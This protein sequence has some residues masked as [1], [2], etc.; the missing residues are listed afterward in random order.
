MTFYRLKSDKSGSSEW[1][2]D[3][4]K[5]SIT[6]GNFD[7]IHRGHQELLKKTRKWADENGG[8]AVVL[9][10]DP[11]PQKVLFPESHHERLF[12]LDDQAEQIQ[13]CAMDA[14]IV[15]KFDLQIASQSADDFL[16][17]LFANF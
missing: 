7:G 6:I 5:L 1:P 13:K 8:V 17:H 10:F 14:V 4:K 16:A 12:D 2:F 11:H 9:T 3:G 15:Q